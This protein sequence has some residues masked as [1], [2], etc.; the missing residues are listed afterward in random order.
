MTARNA[1]SN[2]DVIPRWRSIRRTVEAGEFQRLVVAR[3][4]DERQQHDLAS[5]RDEWLRHRDEVAAS[6]FVGSAL[7]A[8]E[9]S[10][11]HEAAAYLLQSGSTPI[12]QN[13]GMRA[14]DRSPTAGMEPN[15]ERPS[16]ETPA[17]FFYER[18]ARDKRRLKSDPR[19][20]I[21]WTDLARR[22]TVLGQFDLAERA[23]RAALQLAPSSRYVHRVAARFYVHIGRPDKA[24]ALLLRQPRTVEDPWLSAAFLSAASIGG[25]PVGGL[26]RP[27]RL[28]EDD[29]FRA[30]ERAELMSE[31]AT[32]D[33]RGGADKKARQLFQRSLL[34]PTD[35]SLAQVEWASHALPTLEVPLEGL[36]VPYAAEALAL[37]A[38]EKGEWETALRQA[39]SWIDDQPFDTGAA[40]FASYVAAVGLERWAEAAAIAEMGLRARPGD[41]ILTNNLAYSLAEEGRL[42]EAGKVLRRADASMGAA[43]DRVA[44][45]ATAGLIQFRLGEAD[46]GRSLYRSAI[47]RARRAGDQP[48][49][50]MARAMFAREELQQASPGDGLP[51]LLRSLEDFR[52]SIDQKGVL[53]CIDRALRLSEHV[54]PQGR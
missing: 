37:A 5:A 38:G 3:E 20:A 7:V 12:L 54:Q 30:I 46:S 15:L 17:T 47:E 40:A 22:Y 4:L 34:S 23:L 26:K 41:L 18:I 39:E 21:A 35:N 9:P 6:E 28:A 8:G 49:E 42:L 19:N 44:L 25:L 43:A 32:I 51:P 16:S 53:V 24:H 48:L 33:F 31:I 13:L 45:L 1:Q 36:D 14:V 2:R 10:V 52:R 29:R 11:A 50:A 27:R